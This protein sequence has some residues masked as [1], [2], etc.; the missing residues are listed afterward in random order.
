[1]EDI[2]NGY[3][4]SMAGIRKGYLFC[5]KSHIYVG[6]EPVAEKK[7]H[8]Y[9]QN[10]STFCIVT[11]DSIHEKTLKHHSSNRRVLILARRVFRRL[12]RLRM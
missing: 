6:V 11:F 4:L 3:H 10:E 1:M 9:Y 8:G 7:L 5:Q 12:G 2:G